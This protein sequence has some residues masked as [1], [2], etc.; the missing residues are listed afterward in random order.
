LFGTFSYELEV[1][2]VIRD[3]PLISLHILALIEAHTVC[4]YTCGTILINQLRPVIDGEVYLDETGLTSI[5]ESER[6]V[7]HAISVK[8]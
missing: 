6:I 1:I 4:F 3:I 2:P 5:G 8:P 7:R